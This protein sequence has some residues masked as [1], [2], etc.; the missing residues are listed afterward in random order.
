MEVKFWFFSK[1]VT[2]SL[3]NTKKTEENIWR[4]ILLYAK[5]NKL[6]SFEEEASHQKSENRLQKSSRNSSVSI[7]RVY[8]VHL[9]VC[10]HISNLTS[11]MLYS[12]EAFAMFIF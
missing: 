11:F 1:M 2:T 8:R 3:K 5:R 4:K 12:S 9:S 6:Y 7:N 10:N